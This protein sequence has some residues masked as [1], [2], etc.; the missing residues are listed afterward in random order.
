VAHPHYRPDVSD[1]GYAP[2]PAPP[3]LDPVA[4]MR[5]AVARRVET[6]YVFDFWTAFGWTILTCGVYSLY[7]VYRLMWRSVEHN[8]RRMEL[9]EATNAWAWEA[10]RRAGRNA[11]LTPAFQ[12]IAGHLAVLRRVDGEFRDPGIWVVL[13]LF[14]SSIA[15]I[16]AFVLLDGDLVRHE[17]AELLAEAELTSILQALGADVHHPPAPSKAKHNYLNRIVATVCSCGL[18]SLWWLADVMR[19]L[20]EHYRANWIWEDQLPAAVAGLGA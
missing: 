15:Q 3:Q 8:R 9:L 16:V 10:A 6:D 4:R 18:Y 1:P 20:N 12:R 14:G 5:A 19:E 17:E 11:E 2:P 7:V 13:A